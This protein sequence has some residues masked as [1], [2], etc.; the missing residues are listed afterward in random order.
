LPLINPLRFID[1]PPRSKNEVL[2]ALM[3]RMG[4]CEERGS[5]IDKVIFAVEAFQLPAP[6][7]RIAGNSTIAVLFAPRDFAHMDKDER[8]RACYQHACLL[9]VSGK[10]MT[11]TSL[12]QRLGIKDTSY[13]L[14]SRIIGDT[15][16][17]GFIKPHSEGSSSKRDAGY[18]PFWA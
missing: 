15:I 7:F 6:D 3:R 1:E 12:R 14:A 18:V 9:Y 2:T 11:N 13:P 17:I 4:I 5:G 10:R 8:I 16:D